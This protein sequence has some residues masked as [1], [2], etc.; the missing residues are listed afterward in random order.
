[1]GLIGDFPML[2]ILLKGTLVLCP[3]LELNKIYIWV[4]NGNANTFVKVAFFYFLIY[5]YSPALW[6]RITG[7]DSREE[8]TKQ[9]KDRVSGSRTAPIDAVG[10]LTDLARQGGLSWGLYC[11]PCQHRWQRKALRDQQITLPFQQQEGKLRGGRWDVEGERKKLE[12]NF[13]TMTRFDQ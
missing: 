4:I 3:S 13:R 11:I 2:L 9:E 7:T 1:M 6:D 10:S 12:P 5:T 8:R